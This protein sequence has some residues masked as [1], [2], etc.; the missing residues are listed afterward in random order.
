MLIL[1]ESMFKSGKCLKNTKYTYI[2]GANIF[3]Y[4]RNYYGMGLVTDIL[5]RK[6]I[7]GHKN[8]FKST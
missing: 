7:G 5:V 8:F 6:E 3:K 4:H 1:L 2:L